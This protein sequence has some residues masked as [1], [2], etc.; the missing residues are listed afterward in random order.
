MEA[1]SKAIT[2]DEEE[3]NYHIDWKKVMKRLM[4]TNDYWEIRERSRWGRKNT[5]NA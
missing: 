5:K 3:E 2:G 1:K 4:T